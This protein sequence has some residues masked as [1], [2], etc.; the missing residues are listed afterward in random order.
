MKIE[1]LSDQRELDFSRHSHPEKTFAK[2]DPGIAELRLKY[3]ISPASVVSIRDGV[4]YIDA[5]LIK[6]W[7]AER[8]E[9][10]KSLKTKESLLFKQNEEWHKGV[11]SIS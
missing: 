10:A 6:D 4:Q 7:L 8:T 2:A 9:K 1:G 11:D 3:S 5:M